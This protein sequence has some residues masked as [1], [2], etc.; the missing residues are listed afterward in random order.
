M[1]QYTMPIPD[2]KSWQQ[3]RDKNNVPKGAAKVSI[4]DDL[5]AVHKSLSLTTLSKH[6]QAL[7]K[8]L[9][10]IDAYLIVIK[11][12]YP[13]FEPIVT[14]ELKNKAQRHKSFVADLVKATT[15]YYPRYAAV[16]EAYKQLK[17][18]NKGTPKDIAKAMER[19]LGCAAAF[20][21]VDPAKWDKKRQ[22]LNRIMSECEK[23]KTLTPGHEKVIE[24]VLTDL[25][26]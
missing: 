14:K 13:K 7:S 4:G 9:K 16:S 19:L 6:E 15:E 25:K 8:L 3:L 21:L 1:P 2:R 10:D 17:F 12:K 23:A 20:A 11:S 22:G 18:H 24:Q 26:P 5:D